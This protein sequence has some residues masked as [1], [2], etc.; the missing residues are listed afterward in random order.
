[1]LFNDFDFFRFLLLFEY[2]DEEDEEVLEEVDVEL[3]VE[4]DND[5]DDDEVEHECTDEDKDKAFFG[6]AEEDK[7]ESTERLFLDFAAS[8]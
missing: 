2:F 8:M 4:E 3:E 1:M 5:V 7:L 6:K